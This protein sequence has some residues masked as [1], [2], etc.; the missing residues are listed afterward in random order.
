MRGCATDG[1][2]YSTTAV[3]AMIVTTTFLNGL[4]IDGDTD[5]MPYLASR[6]FGNRAVSHIFGWFLFAFFSMLQSGQSPSRN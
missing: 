5:L 1:A 3:H 4:A 6:Y 2:I